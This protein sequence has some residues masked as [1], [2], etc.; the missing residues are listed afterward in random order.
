M[1]EGL[2]WTVLGLIGFTGAALAVP[3]DVRPHAAPVDFGFVTIAQ[4]NPVVELPHLQLEVPVMTV[5]EPRMHHVVQ[6]PRIA[7][8]NERA[9][10]V[11]FDRPG[12]APHPPGLEQRL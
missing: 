3:V 2:L 7:V 1:L 9:R 10:P 6:Q 11:E 8:G 5:L 12:A 4:S